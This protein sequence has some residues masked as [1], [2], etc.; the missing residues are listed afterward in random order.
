MNQLSHPKAVGNK[1]L[2]YKLARMDQQLHSLGSL[3]VHSLQAIGSALDERE[4]ANLITQGRDRRFEFEPSL[5]E[6]AIESAE[7]PVCAFASELPR[8]RRCR[9]AVAGVSAEGKP[10]G[11]S[12]ANE[13]LL[14]LAGIGANGKILALQTLSVEKPTLTGLRI[15]LIIAGPSSSLPVR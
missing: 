12:I 9:I 8:S 2:R 10:S 11:Q 1:L 14:Y 4:I 5:H 6:T 15:A 13:Y 7:E 3:K